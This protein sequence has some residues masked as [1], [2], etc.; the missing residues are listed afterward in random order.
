MQSYT[1]LQYTHLQPAPACVRNLV[2]PAYQEGN[3]TASKDSK[4]MKNYNLNG[5]LNL[6]SQLSA[7]NLYMKFHCSYTFKFSEWRRIAP[8]LCCW[9]HS[10]LLNGHCVGVS[11]AQFTMNH[12][13]VY[14]FW[15]CVCTERVYDE[16]P[17]DDIAVFLCEEPSHSRRQYFS[18]TLRKMDIESGNN[19]TTSGN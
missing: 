18:L 12:K 1:G 6:Y 13:R 16:V 8:C 2:I 7:A 10:V 9:L 5:I 14:V 15:M 3:E 17:L 4:S 19:P 11:I